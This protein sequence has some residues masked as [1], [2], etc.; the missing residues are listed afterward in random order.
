[1]HRR[2]AIEPCHPTL[3]AAGH[4][5]RFRSGTGY[6]AGHCPALRLPA[7]VCQSAGRLAGRTAHAIVSGERSRLSLGHSTNACVDPSQVLSAALRHDERDSGLRVSGAQA[8]RADFDGPQEIIMNATVTT[9]EV[10]PAKI[11]LPIALAVAVLV[12]VGVLL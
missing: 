2:G 3:L 1:R 6:R 12:M 5:R 7:D 8:M 11:K 10:P 4:R 9:P